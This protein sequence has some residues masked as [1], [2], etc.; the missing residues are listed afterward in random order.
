MYHFLRKL[1]SYTLELVSII[2]F[3]YIKPILNSVLK[4]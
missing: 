1:E 2:F 4:L 3:N